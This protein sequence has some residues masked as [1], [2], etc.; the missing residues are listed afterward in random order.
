MKAALTVWDGRISPVCDVSREAVILTIQNGT[1]VAR[2]R[3]NIDA[4]TVALKT[5]RIVELGIKTLVCGAISAPLRLELLAR[6][7]NVVGFVAG[8]IDEVVTTFLAGALPTRALS[9]PGCC[10]TRRRF[11]GGQGVGRGPGPGRRRRNR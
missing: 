10:G 11:R 1:V 3:A 9:M 4:P 8:E 5:D 2:A 6:G 7:V